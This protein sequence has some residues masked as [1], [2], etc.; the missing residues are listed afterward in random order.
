MPPFAAPCRRPASPGPTSGPRC[1]NR[2]TRWSAPCGG[3]CAWPSPSAKRGRRGAA[4]GGAPLRRLTGPPI[5]VDLENRLEQSPPVSPRP[6]ISSGRLRAGTSSSATLVELCLRRARRVASRCGP[7][8]GT[9]SLR[10]LDDG[11]R[12]DRRL[13]RGRFRRDATDAHCSF[14]LREDA[15]RPGTV[16]PGLPARVAGR[17][18]SR[19]SRRGRRNA[20]FRAAGLSTPEGGAVLVLRSRRRRGRGRGRHLHGRGIA[21]RFS[22]TPGW[23]SRRVARDHLGRQLEGAPSRRAPSGRRWNA[24]PRW[25]RPALLL[26]AARAQRVQPGRDEKV[27]P[28]GAP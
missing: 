8:P 25:R 2:P 15:H 1:S 13:Y 3:N 26:A 21:R 10:G 11:G 22:R 17:W 14:P 24:P 5:P 7:T 9:W 20:G 27:R 4:Q 18:A 6:S 16:G 19:V 28:S 12:R 23:A